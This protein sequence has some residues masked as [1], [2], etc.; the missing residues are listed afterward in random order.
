V[1]LSRWRSE[2]ILGALAIGLLDVLLAST[3]GTFR[4]TRG[5]D[6]TGFQNPQ[7]LHRYLEWQSQLMAYIEWAEKNQHLYAVEKAKSLYLFAAYGYTVAIETRKENPKAWI[8]LEQAILAR[9]Q[10]L[11]HLRHIYDQFRANPDQYFELPAN[12]DA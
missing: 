9:I 10:R 6:I 12:F 5:G 4:L 8:D 7:E 1:N 3:P 2:R 11:Q